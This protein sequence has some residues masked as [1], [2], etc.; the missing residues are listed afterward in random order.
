MAARL[1]PA[2]AATRFDDVVA[3]VRGAPMSRDPSSSSSSSS[4]PED[5]TMSRPA[6]FRTALS[7]S[8]SSSLF[9]STSRRFLFALALGVAGLAGAAG[10]VA[11]DRAALPTVS[12]TSVLPEQFLRGFDPVTVVFA[13]DTGPGPGPADDA[14]GF[15]SLKPAWPGAWTWADKRT[16]QFRPAEPWP[17]L[18]R[19]AVEAKGASRVLSTMMTAPQAMQPADGSTGLP[20]FRTLTLTFP[21][22]LALDALQ[23]MIRLEVRDLPGL[24]DQ[25]RQQIEKFSLALLPRA[26]QKD[27]ATYAISFD[28]D[29]GEG[30]MLVVTVA[31]ALS[32]VDGTLW[33]G[34]ASTR[35]DFRLEEVQC[36]GLRLGI[37]GSPKAP[38]EQALDCGSA[39]Q[40]PQLVFSAPVNN[41]SLTALKKLVRLEPS[42]P[43]LKP[44]LFGRYVQL[45]GRFVPD[46]LYR[47]KIADAPVFDDLGRR[48]KNPGEADVYFFVGWKKP[49]LRVKR[50]AITAEAKG[51]RMLPLVGYGDAKADV[52]IHRIDPL[53]TGLW[54]F[55]QEP[56]VVDESTEPPSP[57]YEPATPALP[58]LVSRED[59]TGHLRLLGAPIVSRVVDLP[60]ADKGGTT[61]FGLD[62]GRLL[63]GEKAIGAKRPGTYLVG[64]RRLQGSPERSWA[65]VQVTNLSVTAVE[66]RG[67]AV[68]FV[69]ALDTAAPVDGAK[70]TFDAVDDKTG[71]P[72]T[73]SLTTDGSGRASLPVQPNW[74]SLSRVVVGKGDD[75]LVVDPSNPPPRFANNHWG[76]SSSWLPRF[77]NNHWGPSS[78]WLSSITTTVPVPKN[79]AT[80]G[81]LFT[82]RPI[83]RPGEKVFLKGFVREKKGGVL[84]FPTAPKNADGTAGAAPKLSIKVT[85]PGDATWVLPTTTT[86]LFGGDAVWQ[87]KDPPT[88]SYQAE[89]F[90]AGQTTALATRRFQVEAYRLPTF[91]L[92]L[93]GPMTARLDQPFSVRALARYY[94]GGNVAG[95][96]VRW[97]ITRRPAWHVPKGRDGFLFASSAQFARNESRGGEEQTTREATL[98]DDGTDVVEVNPQKDI[99]GSPR[100]YRFEATVKGADDQEVSAVTEVTALPPFSLG[101]KLVRFAKSASSVDPEIIAVGVDDNLVEGQ[102]VEVRLYKRSWHSHLRESHFATGE[103]QYVTEQ[104]DKKVAEQTLTTKAAGPVKVALPVAGAGVYVVELAARDKLGRVQTLSADLYIGG[105]EPVA[106]AKGQAGVFE[107][108]PDKAAPA[109]YRP[110]ETA[111]V[112][113]KSPFQRA[114]ALVIVER[115]SGNEYK[116]IDVDGGTAVVPVAIDKSATPNLPVHVVLTRGRLGDSATDDAPYRPQTVASSIDLEVEPTKNVIKVELS[117]PEQARPGSTIDMGISLKDDAGAPLSGEVTLWLVDEAVLAL[118]KEGVLDPLTAMVVRNQRDTTVTDT[119]NQ[120]VGRVIEDE[121]PGGDGGDD[122]DGTGTARRRV[123]KDFQTVPYW[124]ATLAVPASGRLSVKVALSDDLTNFAIRAVAASGAERF[125]N[126]ASKIRVRLPVLVQ[127]QLPRFVRQG[128]RFDGGGVARL[129]EG[130]GGPGVVKAEYIGPVV[131]RKRSKDITLAQNKAESVTFPVEVK[132]TA[133]GNALTVK[134]EVYKKKDGTGDA[135]EVKIPVLPDTAPRTVAFIDDIGATKKALSFPTEAARPGTMSQSIVATNV[136][137]LFEVVGALEYLDAYPHGCLE[138]KMARLAPQLATAALAKRLGGFTYAEGVRAHVERLLV[139]LTTYQS[140]GGLFGY[141]P[142]SVGDVQ[143]TGDALEFLA[144]AEQQK[145]VVDKAVKKKAQ[146]ALKAALR[147]DY[148]WGSWSSF[149]PSLQAGALRAL[150]R[151]GDVDEHYLADLMRTR[152]NLDA[153][154]RADLALA[155]LGKAS[156]FGSDLS[157]L[158]GELWTSVTFQLVDGK[159]VVAGLNDPR[160]QWGS[161]FLGSPTSSLATVLEALV[162]LDPQ[163]PD[164]LPLVQALLKRGAGQRGFGSTYDNRRA[165]AALVTW[166]DKAITE[167]ATTKLVLNDKTFTLDGAVKV[168]R[169]DVDA[170]TAPQAQATGQPVR[171]RVRY[172]YQP[173]TPGDRQAAQKAGFLVD[174]SMTIYPA[175]APEGTAPQRLDDVRA[176]ERTL[177]TGDVVEIHAR[178]TVDKL[179]HNIAFVV[180]FAAGLEPLNPALATASSDAQPA[181]RDS[182]TPLYVERL[183]HEVRY[184]FS[185]LAAGT[186]AFHF[187]AKAITP[188]SYVHPGAYAELMYDESVRGSSDGLRVVVVRGENPVDDDE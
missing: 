110:G 16:L 14:S 132:S 184:Y 141:W 72:V 111:N 116:N 147:S 44:T 78:S 20:P 92:Q 108:V 13:D 105:K 97:S 151:G 157:T 171:A 83:Y 135:F 96:P 41:L 38:R 89:L 36:A 170:T 29:V 75:V 22:P 79:D 183:D 82:E 101:M 188:G 66:E 50:G 95:Q 187:R 30:K 154:S 4:S 59:L 76:P 31:L 164:L 69:R 6:R 52:R 90:V 15:A 103:A 143:L 177:S 137:G 5:Q 43:D 81:F 98:S 186:Y 3:V 181:E 168:A 106:W 107:L 25:P 123:R 84:S 23:K 176:A 17:A 48:L 68:F 35:T 49:F 175:S 155:M 144:M 120:V 180:P 85:G 174:R 45:D 53:H 57:G 9:P 61:S 129:V 156:T 21:Q 1:L 149:R 99:D 112:V 142:G 42:V 121:A 93:A 47:L 94:A 64:V 118:A 166:L 160:S 11:A 10:Y 158:K 128:D 88:G 134:M 114:N 133:S 37:T 115:A 139:E 117:H 70:V 127:P 167:T 55:P 80:L 126:A 145:I 56:V 113:V 122:G 146:D 102:K 152:S 19:F 169:Y 60:L 33:T 28:G 32:D 54:P 182:T 2:C 12:S 46:T 136:P 58:S 165:I 91:E 119:R 87:E 125:G 71:K 8:S 7:T 67:Q 172:R 130:D 100:T 131:E 74:R 18:A 109:K 40:T 162:R 51:P 179:R 159:R 138:Q 27:P 173:E 65:R 150:V 86:A 140:D 34:R 62:V 73:L 163:N 77:A 24:G 185:S 63:D 161:A 104:E 124:Q 26:D 153:T 148:A 39:G 178:F